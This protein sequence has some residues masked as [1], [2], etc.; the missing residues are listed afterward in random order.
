MPELDCYECSV[1]LYSA[2]TL[3]IIAQDA[4]IPLLERLLQQKDMLTLAAVGPALS[5]L[6]WAG[7]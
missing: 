4:A 5:G 6:R 3:G 1:V 7:F 2:G